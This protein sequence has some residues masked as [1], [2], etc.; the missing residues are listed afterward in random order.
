MSQKRHSKQYKPPPPINSSNDF[1]IKLLVLNE[2][3][4]VGANVILRGDTGTG[5]SELFAVYSGRAAK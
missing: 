4:R 1:G 3:K 2:R 5:K